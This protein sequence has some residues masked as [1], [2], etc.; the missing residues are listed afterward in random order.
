MAASIDKQVDALVN[1]QL[2]GVKSRS[3]LMAKF[4]A[5]F[6]LT[7]RTFWKRNKEA[8]AIYKEK[9]EMMNS[10]KDEVYKKEAEKIAK[11]EVANAVEVLEI[12]TEALRRKDLSI[13]ELVKVA[14]EVNKM[15]G[16]HSTQK[17]ENTIK[18]DLSSWTDDELV[19][20]LKRLSNE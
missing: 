17:I 16:G 9:I 12:L 11:L 4:Q 7:D 1:W 19:K 3:E 8:E 6:G 10:A 15:I 14:N 20:E 13:T 5:E 2:E 18:G